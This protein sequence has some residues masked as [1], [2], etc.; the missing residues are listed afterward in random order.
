MDALAEMGD[1]E[2]RVTLIEMGDA[3]KEVV[4]QCVGLSLASIVDGLT[5]TL[6]ATSDEIAA[7]DAIQY[8]DGGPCVVS[9]HENEIVRVGGDEM[10]TEHE[11]LLYA[12]ASAAAGVA[13]SLTLP[14]LNTGR[15]IGTVNLYAATSDAFEG[16]EDDLAQAVGA[17]A[18]SAVRN[19]DLGFET[20]LEAAR[21][22][23]RLVDQNDVDIAL[24]I[25]AGSQRVDIPTAQERLRQA[26]ARAH[27]T[28]AQA[29]R[30]ARGILHS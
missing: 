7:L 9:A 19:A 20:R 16:R 11:W 18:A 23:E 6:V 10:I 25:I 17:S 4:P 1:A 14:I 8:L 24:G 2:M 27:I 29:A 15:V 21:A 13:S 12:Q 26:A 3:A 5:F 30:A 28:E 22:P